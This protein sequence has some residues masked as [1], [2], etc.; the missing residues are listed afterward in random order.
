MNRRRSSDGYAMLAALLIMI[1]AAT[2]A[3][4]VFGA[5]HNLQVVE[6]SDAA[7]WRVGCGRRERRGSG[8]RSPAVAARG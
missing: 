5:V 8:D 1:L 2:F 3:L 4:V 7:G 6:R